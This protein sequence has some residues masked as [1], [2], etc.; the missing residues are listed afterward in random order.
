MD[1]AH[2]GTALEEVGEE[3]GCPSSPQGGAQQTCN[4]RVRAWAEREGDSRTCRSQ[5]VDE[6]SI[7]CHR[8]P[9]LP[10]SG[11]VRCTPGRGDA[12]GRWTRCR[13]S[14]GKPRGP[15]LSRASA[16]RSSGEV[17]TRK[18]GRLPCI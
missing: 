16:Q 7:G 5:T 15:R 9:R 4:Q 2:G 8:W 3:T 10:L 11:D 17:A 14:G 12:R 13:R 6:D 18:E 1:S